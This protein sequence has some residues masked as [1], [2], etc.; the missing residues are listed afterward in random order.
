MLRQHPSVVT[1]G[2]WPLLWAL[3]V[4]MHPISSEVQLTPFNALI[5]TGAVEQL[6]PHS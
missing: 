4:P 6:A 1:G 2:R 5:S 3:L